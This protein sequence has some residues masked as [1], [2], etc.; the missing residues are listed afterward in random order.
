M[1]I[2]KRLV[3]IVCVL[4]LLAISITPTILA[5]DFAGNEDYYEEL[6]KG[7]DLT[8]QEEATCEDFRTYLNDRNLELTLEQQ[9]IEEMREEIASNIEDKIK[10]IDNYEAQ[11]ASLQE[12]IDL[13]N[14]DIATLQVSIDEAIALIAQKELEKEELMTKVQD[15]MVSSQGTM[16][17]N[18]HVDYLMGAQSFSE[19]IRRGNWVNDLLEYDEYERQELVTLID[20]INLE[21]EQLIVDQDAVEVK[22][23]ETLTKQSEINTLQ[24][25]AEIILEEW[26]KQEQE[27]IALG[28][29]IAADLDE[30]K[31][32]I[33]AMGEIPASAGF[34][35]PTTSTR[36]T[37]NTWSYPKGGTH[38]GTDIGIPIG[39]DLYAV[40]N[41]IVIASVDG[42][43]NNGY[44]GNVC[45]SAQGGT[46]G[47]G[48]QLIL[49][50][51][52]GG[53]LYAIKYLHL[54]PGTL[55][56]RYT[57]VTQG[58]VIA[59]SG[60]SGNSSGAHLHLEVY[61]LGDYSINDYIA[62]WNGDLSFGCGWGTSALS[63]L[64]ENSGAPCRMRPEEVF[65]YPEL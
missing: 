46:S 24:A 4:S 22:R 15:R 9:N 41:G 26:L 42:C 52:V 20:D 38:L 59:E 6:C 36:V 35:R 54:S 34:I 7:T 64:C 18:Q 30:I 57:Q 14:A 3:A 45:G 49:L 21:K 63:R 23:A 25:E 47:G 40:A 31:S 11:I 48:N 28:N 65:G 60:N 39:T 10:E 56:A 58:D 55:V 8:A 27:W 43:S 62:S 17:L 33:E 50:T 53:T 32:A 13:L 2:C 51:Q 61:K 19:F 44:L 12:E 29:R 16:R 5:N 37:A 1:K